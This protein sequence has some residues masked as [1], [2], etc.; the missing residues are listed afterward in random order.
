MQNAVGMHVPCGKC[1]FCLATKRTQW[2]LRIA[3]EYI[4]CDAAQFITLTYAEETMPV[5]DGLPQ[6]N[7]EDFQL[8]MKRLR[9]M[10][11]GKLRYYA[12]GE[13][14][15]I[16]ERPHYHLILFN[17]PN[18]HLNDV[19]NAWSKDGQPI[20]H[21]HVGKV[22]PASIHYVTKYV[23]NKEIVYPGREPPFALMSRRPGIGY[24]Y[25]ETHK[26]WH[27]ADLRNYMQIN[28]ITTLLPRY[29][30]EKLYSPNQRA[31]MAAVAEVLSDQSWNDTIQKLS[32]FH[33]DPYYYHE[34]RIS[35]LHN[36]K[37]ESNATL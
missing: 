21:I 23:I 13:Y 24:Q 33:H 16:L 20:G 14:G 15:E 36:K 32:R 11:P 9:K 8:F 7:K 4:H 17:L 19:V 27:N 30:K 28:G 5:K 31:H 22:E 35:F 29:Y 18:T 10:S 37:L 25:L 2:S 6:L 12:V 26:S 34:E 3:Q 1:N